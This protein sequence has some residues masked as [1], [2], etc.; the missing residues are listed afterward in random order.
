MTMKNIISNYFRVF[1]TL[2][3]GGIFL[4]SCAVQRTAPSFEAFQP[5]DLESAVASGEYMQ[6]VDN[7]LVLMDVSSSMNEK[8]RQGGLSSSPSPVKFDAEKELLN[9]MNQ[10]IPSSLNLNAALRSFGMGPCLGWKS[11]K[12]EYGVT[13]YSRSGFEEALNVNKCASGGTPM[14]QGLDGTAGDLAST[15]GDIAVILFSDGLHTE[16]NPLIQAQELK[17]QYGNRLCIYTVWLGD[18]SSDPNFKGRDLLKQVAYIS[19]CGAPYAAADIAS[20]QGMGDFVTKVFLKKGD[21][22]AADEDSDGVNN[23]EDQCPGTPAGAHVNSIGCWVAQVNFDFD[24]SVVKSE[25]YPEL[26]NV[27]RIMTQLH[28]DLHIEVQGWAS[29]VGSQAYNLKLS[30][31][32]ADAVK[33]YLIKQGVSPNRLNARGYGISYTFPNDTE[34]GRYENQRVQF[35]RLQ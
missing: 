17:K 15:Q 29:A 30:Q 5:V 22:C 13:S 9:R 10:T 28:P 19:G 27:A 33:E 24:K 21:R 14:G 34:Q 31:R 12:L 4:A 11:S 1:Y 26:N 35:K 8:Y 25:F 18:D 3:L 7:F 2:L 6:K 32:R 16:G 20:S 23:C